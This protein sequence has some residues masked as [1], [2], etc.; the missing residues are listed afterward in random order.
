RYPPNFQQGLRR[1]PLTTE[2]QGSPLPFG[3]NDTEVA[4]KGKR[5]LGQGCWQIRSIELV[6][7][8]Y[9]L[10]C[11]NGCAPSAVACWRAFISSICF[12]ISGDWTTSCPYSGSTC[13]SGEV[14]YPF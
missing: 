2:Q 8:H 5:Q 12:C 9:L 7:S 11:T 14:A 6:R 13:R 4:G 3:Q 10:P 1:D